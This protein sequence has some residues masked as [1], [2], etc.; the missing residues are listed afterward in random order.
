MNSQWL[1][2]TLHSWRKFNFTCSSTSCA[3]FRIGLQA[4]HVVFGDHTVPAGA[5]LVTP[6]PDHSCNVTWKSSTVCASGSGVNM[7]QL[8][9]RWMQWKLRLKHV[10]NVTV[11]TQSG[12]LQLSRMAV[13]MLLFFFPTLVLH[14]SP[15]HLHDSTV[16]VPLERFY[17]LENIS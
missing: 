17:D 3:I 14:L 12:L 6:A 8:L 5:V 2:I 15:W 9:T 11:L 13:Q 7:S 10:G 16:F 1:I 4:V